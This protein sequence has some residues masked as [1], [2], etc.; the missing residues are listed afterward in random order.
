MGAAASA[1]LA[2]CRIVST[3]A[4]VCLL[5]SAPALGAKKESPQPSGTK[6]AEGSFFAVY[7]LKKEEKPAAANYVER[8]YQV[9]IVARTVKHGTQRYTRRIA[10]LDADLL[11]SASWQIA[12]LDGDGLEDL[13]YLAQQTKAGCRVWPA[14]R[15][16]KDRERF[17]QGGAQLARH[18]D[19]RGKKV[20]NC[21]LR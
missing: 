10:T 11:A 12:D 1:A 20:P 13:R 6:V 14:L 2:K 21:A 8:V 16:E 9:T 3:A 19:G 7:V 17:T 18:V 4:V 15:W 5:A